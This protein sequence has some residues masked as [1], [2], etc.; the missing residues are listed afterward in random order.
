MPI[1]VNTEVRRIRKTR[2]DAIGDV[3]PPPELA[4]DIARENAWTR[5]YR[6]AIGDG[7]ATARAEARACE[8]VGIDRPAAWLGTRSMPAV[9][10]L[11]RTAPEGDS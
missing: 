4:D 11:V 3:A 2:T 9:G 6:R 10:H 5:E 7:E 1:H 8:A